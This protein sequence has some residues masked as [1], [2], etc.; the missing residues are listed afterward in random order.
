MQ[1]RIR[2]LSFLLA[3]VFASILATTARA[4]EVTDW[5]QILFQPALVAQTSPLIM[6]RNAAIV[7][8]SV[9]DAVNGI[10]R[11]YTPIHVK[12]DAPHG[13][14]A[15]AAAVQAAYVSLVNLYPTQ[16]STFGAARATS[17]DAI[18]NKRGD[19]KKGDRDEQQERQK[20]VDPWSRMGAGDCGLHLDLAKH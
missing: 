2:T 9:Y 11:R 5:N 15:R 13:A 1:R 4:D 16:Q 12:P 14:S 3:V 19:D 8:A 6:A 17:L 7:R 18:L 10:E 20:A